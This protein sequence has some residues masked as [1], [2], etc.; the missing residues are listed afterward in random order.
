MI[1]VPSLPF[2]CHHASL[3]W[4]R[5]QLISNPQTEALS[6]PNPQVSKLLTQFVWSYVNTWT[7]LYCTS[8][9]SCTKVEKT[10]SQNQPQMHP[11]CDDDHVG[12]KFP[13]TP[14]PMN[15]LTCEMC[16]R[17]VQ[18]ILVSVIITV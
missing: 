7:L 6:F 12:V 16:R 5:V 11:I 4:Y 17:E 15:C 13:S 3:A 14:P 1:L 18:F 2:H 8:R 9:N 10:S